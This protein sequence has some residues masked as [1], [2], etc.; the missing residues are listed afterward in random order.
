MELQFITLR[1]RTETTT[2][3]HHVTM[4]LCMGDR[5]QAIRTWLRG[6]KKRATSV[7]VVSQFSENLNKGLCSFDI[8]AGAIA[9]F[10]NGILIGTEGNISVEIR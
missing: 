9:H 2:I 7:S 3:T 1:R 5:V 10:N 8:G 6:S 4:G